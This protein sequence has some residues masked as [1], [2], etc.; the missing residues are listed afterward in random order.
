MRF[1]IV[2]SLLTLSISASAQNIFDKAIVLKEALVTARRNIKESGQTRTV[3]DS[4]A[5][6]ESLNLSFAELLTKHS[7]LFVKTY[8]LGSMATVSFRGTAASHTQVEWNGLNINNPMLGQVDFSM[9]PVWL[10]D[11]T[12]LLH[13][14]SSLQEGSGAL[15]GSVLISSR[16]RW[17]DNFYGSVM[18]GVGSF[19]NYQTS[20][21]VG[22]GSRKFQSRIRYI[23][24]QAEN[25]FEFKN[26]AVPPFDDQKQTNADY[27]KHAAVADLFW[28]AGKGHF[29]S[30]NGWFHTANRNLPTI[31]SYEGRGRDEWQ[32]DDE[33][34]IVGKWAY[35]GKHIKSEFTGGY[36]TT[37]LDYYLANKT[38]MGSVLNFDSRSAVH[39]VQGKYKFDWTL[40]D[41]TLLR[42][43]VDAAHHNVKTLNHIT[44]EGYG[45]QRT[46]IG[47]SISGHHRFMKQLS[48]YGLVRY[49]NNGA[50]MPSAGVEYEPI[51]NLIF[52][53]NGTRNYHQPT[54]N[55]LHWLPG[56]NPDLRP[57]RGYTVDVNGEYSLSKDFSVGAV[58]YLSW[59]D[60]WI[61]WRPSEFR[62]WTATNIRKVFARGIEFNFTAGH[63]FGELRINLHSNY[64]YTRTTNE[65]PDLLDDES[66]GKQL[67]YIPRH[68]AN[69]MLDMT[70]KGFYLYYNWSFVSERFT[71]S[72]NSTTRHTLP[73]YDLH[74]VTIGKKLWKFDIQIKVDN[75]FNKDYQ[76]ILWRAMPRRNY[77]MLLRFDF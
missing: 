22:G 31:M 17:D 19:G 1:A 14:G 72:S 57:E 66:K 7:P 65:E 30:L 39:T 53:L 27:R 68:K 33:L 10:V 62:Y 20:V 64:A 34:R 55:D 42:A 60:D 21:S 35:Y 26:S 50:F 32:R 23:Y 28:N 18:Q 74:N 38:D 12:E 6:A 46:D 51:R 13:G 73:S 75:L 37:T 29:V 52:K 2:I 54:L 5:I 3:I 76:A 40:S 24:Q 25:N 77:T 8:G 16:P 11:Q 47:V 69:A 49:E 61:I 4:T 67:I 58:G 44:A 70:Y 63:S 59:I 41:K 9:I 43:I 15:G 71:S 45:A 48:G 36:S 56:G